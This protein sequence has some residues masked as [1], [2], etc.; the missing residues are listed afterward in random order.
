MFDNTGVELITDGN[1][2]QIAKRAKVSATY[3]ST[4]GFELLGLGLPVV[5]TNPEGRCP[6]LPKEQH[7]L[8]F[9]ASNY[10]LFQDK[11]IKIV[12]NN[13]PQND[14]AIKYLSHESN[15]SSGLLIK[16]IEALVR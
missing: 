3:Y 1:S 14:E 16:E 2:Y 5:F 9:E 7:F 10:N 4:I 8:E 12:K 6:Y 11:V 13:E 15:H